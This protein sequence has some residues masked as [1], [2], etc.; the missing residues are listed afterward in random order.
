ML[1]KSRQYDEAHW[2]TTATNA[3]IL[4]FYTRN[5]VKK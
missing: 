1:I 2:C 3:A 5:V 4:A